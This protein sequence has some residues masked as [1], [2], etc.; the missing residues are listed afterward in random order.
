MIT[1]YFKKGFTLLELLVVI[2]ILGILSALITGN[3]LTSLKKGRDAQRKADLQQM[4]RANELYYADQGYYATHE[5]DFYG[6]TNG[7][8]FCAPPP[9]GCSEKIY[10]VKVPKDPLWN[11]EYDVDPVSG[12]DEQD[13]VIYA[14][15]EN[16]DDNG[17]GTNQDSDGYSLCTAGCC[18]GQAHQ[19][20]F[21]VTSPNVTPPP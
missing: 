6:G 14:P 17:P 15:L 13:F 12:T 11:C 18:Q 8:Q 19:G 7:D 10:M 20:R 1:S 16:R 2:A 5:D 9:G 3:F 21:A 4:K